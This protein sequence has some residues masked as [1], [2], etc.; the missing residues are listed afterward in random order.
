MSQAQ[1]NELTP[2][3]A[4]KKRNRKLIKFAV[5]LVIT[6]AALAFAI[7]KIDFQEF[8]R[9]LQ[10]ANPY[11]FVAAVLCFN[12]SKVIAA[13]RLRQFYA[14]IGLVLG[15]WY[16]LKLY[17]LGMF[18]NLFL[19]GAI[20]GDAY[21]VYALRSP[22]KGNTKA[23]VWATLADRLSGLCLLLLIG[24]VFYLFSNFPI[25][26][27]WEVTTIIMLASLGSLP[28]FYLV[29]KWFLNKKVMRKFWVTSHYSF[30]VQIGQVATA[31]CLLQALHI[32]AHYLD[33]LTLFMLSSVAAVIPITVAGVGLREFVFI[34]GNDFLLIDEAPAVAFA[35]LFFFA[36]AT[37]SLLGAIFAFRPL[38]QDVT[39]T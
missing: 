5:K 9:N 27:Q 33:Y 8:Q 16:N 25:V 36:L 28:G 15:K 29:F 20:G 11:W 10:A 14:N 37:A 38:K 31:L 17:Y 2:E 34:Q 6:G 3:Q 12:I 13:F 7:H 19:P 18:Y 1:P 30:W 21:K 22:E 26:E 4:R 23:L 24:T 39:F 32:P 35:I